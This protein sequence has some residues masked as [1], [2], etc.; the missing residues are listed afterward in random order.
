MQLTVLPA[1]ASSR[2]DAFLSGRLGISRSDALRLLEAGFVS[3]N[4][5]PLNPKAKGR[6][7]AAGDLI[8]VRQLEALTQLVPDSVSPLKVLVETGDVIIVDK[9]AGMPVM[10]RR[11]QETG[12]VLNAV[13]ARYPQLQGVGEGGL[14]SGVVHRLDTETSGAL[15][16]ALTETAWQ[17]LREDFTEHR[18]EK[19]YHAIVQGRCPPSGDDQ[20]QL[21]VSQ[22]HPAKVA[23]LPEPMRQSRS[24]ALSYQ[25]L[26]MLKGAT[27]IEVRLETGFLHQIRVMM[28]HLGHP[29]VGDGHYGASLQARRTMLHAA[30]LTVDGVTAVSPIPSDFEATLAQLALPE[31]EQ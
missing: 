1:E 12:T 29:V 3:H 2:L 27:L 18:T 17:R 24:C 21:V 6:R 5:R 10:P 13:V 19:I 26:K 25:T 8:V 7:L 14:R 31:S 4:S 23:V 22:H 30:R 11:P 9:P 16:V 28:A 15:A 20:M